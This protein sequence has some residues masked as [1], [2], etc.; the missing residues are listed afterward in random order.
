VNESAGTLAAVGTVDDDNDDC[1]SGVAI[2]AIGIIAI[3]GVPV[4]AVPADVVIVGVASVTIPFDTFDT[5]TVL[6][7][8]CDKSR[9]DEPMTMLGGSI[10]IL[11][12]D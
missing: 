3:A 7:D 5:S 6:E 1:I 11:L 9:L 12:I 10:S 4:A 8:D 2:A